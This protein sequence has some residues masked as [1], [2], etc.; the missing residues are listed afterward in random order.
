MQKVAD[1]FET[2]QREKQKKLFL[3]FDDLL[4]ESYRLLSKNNG[5]Y[6]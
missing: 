3:D 2:Y 4:V 5:V 6:D 1:L